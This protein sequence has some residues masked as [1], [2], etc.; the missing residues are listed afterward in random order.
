MTEQLLRIPEVA[1]RLGLDGSDVYE[2]V[3]TGQLAAGKGNDGLVYVR[4]SVLEDYER[5]RAA[6]AQ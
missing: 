5:R 2:L 4:E 1:R 6:T 3:A